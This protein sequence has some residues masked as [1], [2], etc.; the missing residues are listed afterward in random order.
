[1]PVEY[2]KRLLDKVFD[3]DQSF[4]KG[5]LK[6]DYLNIILDFIGGEATLCM[7]FVDEVT[8]YFILQ[9]VNRGKEHWLL[10]FEVW[11]QTNGTTY[12]QPKVQKYIQ[13][14]SERLDLPITLDGSKKC[15][16][17]CRKYHNGKGSYD[18]VYKAIKHYIAAYGKYPNTKIT[19]SPDNINSMF[20]AIKAMIDL[21]YLGVRLSCV[22]EDVW[23]ETHDDIFK[24]QME[25]FYEYIESR[26]LDF[27]LYP[28]SIPSTFQSSLQAG[29]CGSYGNMLCLDCHGKLYLCQRFTEISNLQDKP[30]LSIGNID[31]GI[32]EQGLKIIEQIKQSIDLTKQTP[33][34]INCAIGSACE[35]CPAFNYEHFGRTYGTIK[36]N[37][38]KMHIA[39]DLLL[40]H[41]EKLQNKQKSSI[42][43]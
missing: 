20:E 9:C 39:H 36:T 6:N 30:S 8:E 21:G 1:M 41:L 3:N 23:N 24:E 5:F 37:C 38:K 16:D 2:A 33:H 35:S 42:T 17:A 7:D 15:H 13:K 19:I 22:E 40:Q 31:D 29:T 4:F 10:N 18:D 43:I 32:T 28:Y 34:C 26:N 25:K 12:F 11:L 27:C 14:H